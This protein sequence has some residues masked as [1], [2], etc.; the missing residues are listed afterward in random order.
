LVIARLGPLLDDEDLAHRASIALQ[1]AV[2]GRHRS[3]KEWRLRWRDHQERRNE[4]S[5]EGG[6]EQE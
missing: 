2:D 5:R 4:L 1:A 6:P 3:V